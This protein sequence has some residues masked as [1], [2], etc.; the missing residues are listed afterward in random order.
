MPRIGSLK[1]SIIR[2]IVPMSTIRTSPLP[3][4]RTQR[5]RTSACVVWRRCRSG[6]WWRTSPVLVSQAGI[7]WKAGMAGQGHHTSTR[8]GPDVIWSLSF[9]FKLEA[10]SAAAT[11]LDRMNHTASGN[12]LKR[13]SRSCARYTAASIDSA[14]TLISEI[15][16][17][18][19]LPGRIFA[20]LVSPFVAAFVVDLPLRE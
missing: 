7:A 15:R 19:R 8:S 17:N 18:C 4:Q 14:H 5:R 2:L 11:V 10:G 16:L 3:E 12:H 9:D 1:A 13:W 6:R 20:V